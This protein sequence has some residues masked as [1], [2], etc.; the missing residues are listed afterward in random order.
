MTSKSQT[1]DTK[2]LEAAA[3]V[4]V[5]DETGKSVLFGSLFENQKT[6]VVFIREFLSFPF[7]NEPDIFTGS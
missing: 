7:E 5:W 2:T 4:P 6:I 1:V 3:A